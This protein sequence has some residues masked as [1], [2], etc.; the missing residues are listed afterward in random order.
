MIADLGTEPKKTSAT[1]LECLKE[2]RASKKKD[3]GDDGD[4]DDAPCHHQSAP[5]RAVRA[6]GVERRQWADPICRRR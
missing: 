6:A 5:H 3:D 4:E 1:V 2:S